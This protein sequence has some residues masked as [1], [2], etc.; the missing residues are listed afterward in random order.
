MAL[1]QTLFHSAAAVPLWL[2]DSPH[3]PMMLG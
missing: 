3:P 2:C 1:L